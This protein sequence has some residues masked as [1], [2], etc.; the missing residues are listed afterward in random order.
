[1]NLIRKIAET[2]L[3]VRETKDQMGRIK[4]NKFLREREIIKGSE[5]DQS[6]LEYLQL[7]YIKMAKKS[8]YL[9]TRTQ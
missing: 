8:E 3:K 5:K 4:K 7:E 6:E 1:M 2:E 9:T